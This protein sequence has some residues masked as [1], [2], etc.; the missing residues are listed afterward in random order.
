MHISLCMDTGI[1]TQEHRLKKLLFWE[2]PLQNV[3][4]LQRFVVAIFIN[5]IQGIYSCNHDADTFHSLDNNSQHTQEKHLTLIFH[6]LQ[7]QPSVRCN[8][9]LYLPMGRY[10]AFIIQLNWHKTQNSVSTATF[11]YI[12]ADKIIIK[13]WQ[14]SWQTLKLFRFKL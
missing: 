12:I 11:F 1:M 8:F 4:R 2:C 10:N 7:K 13:K 3:F 5:W 9:L 14:K 6:M